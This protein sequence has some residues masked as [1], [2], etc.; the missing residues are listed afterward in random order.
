MDKSEFYDFFTGLLENFDISET[1]SFQMLCLQP[2]LLVVEKLPGWK[3]P[4][5][6]MPKNASVRG[7]IESFSISDIITILNMNRKTGILSFVFNN[8]TKSLYFIKG[9]IIYATSSME[10]DRL[11]EVLQRMGKLSTADISRALKECGRGEHFGKHLVE[12]KKITPKEL[13][14]AVRLQVEEIVYSIFTYNKGHFI[15]FDGDIN[16]EGITRISMNTQNTLMEGIRRIDEWALMQEKLPSG[17]LIMQKKKHP[18]T[19]PLHAE[20]ETIFRLVD[21]MSTISDLQKLTGM[22][23][24]NT[25]KIVYHLMIGGFIEYSSGDDPEE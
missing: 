19:T 2:D 9:E 12:T 3:I 1:D 17:D 4:G 16:S 21:G 11:G 8:A 15:F 7:S 22:P 18:P 25:Y 24:F 10:R 13:F 20:E 14:A 5:E 23:E 6:S